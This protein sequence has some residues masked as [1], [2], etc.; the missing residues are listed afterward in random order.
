MTI[1]LKLFL[2]III[3]LFLFFSVNSTYAQNNPSPQSSQEARLPLQALLS[4][5]VYLSA[6][7]LEDGMRGFGLNEFKASASRLDENSVQIS[8]EISAIKPNKADQF[9]V[10]WRNQIDNYFN[11][12][13]AA[14]NKDEAKMDLAERNLDNFSDQLSAL[15][16]DNDSNLTNELDQ[17][18][19]G[20]ISTVLDSIDAYIKGDYDTFTKLIQQEFTNTIN[21]TDRLSLI[22]NR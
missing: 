8:R 18:F 17:M 15:I 19:T 7:A 16:S 13:L 5:H 21:Q 22:L 12:A 9:L 4:E 20:R 2:L 10:L 11:Y 14:K 3:S 1:S 6:V